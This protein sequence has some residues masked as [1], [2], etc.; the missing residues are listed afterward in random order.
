MARD[1][2]RTPRDP[3]RKSSGGANKRDGAQQ[4]AASWVPRRGRSGYGLESIRPHLRAQL[5][6]RKLW[7]QEFPPQ[8][9]EK[10]RDGDDE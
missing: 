9:D 6:Q 7:R 4:H 2:S 8:M 1:D 3:E 5:E 10:K